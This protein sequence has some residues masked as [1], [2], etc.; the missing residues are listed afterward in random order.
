MQEHAGCYDAGLTRDPTLAG[1]IEIRFTIAPDGSVSAA[2]V[3]T[4]TL[5]DE[6]VG[7]CTA[8]AFARWTFPKPSDGGVVQVIF[9]LS[10]EP[11]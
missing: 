10:L 7:K 5:S 2:T 6:A 11:G 3:S 4:N 8:K 9:P 1:R